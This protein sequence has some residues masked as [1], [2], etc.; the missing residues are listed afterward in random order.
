MFYC[1]LSKNGDVK[2]SIN[3]FFNDFGSIDILINN[4]GILYNGP[5]V[6]FKKGELTKHSISSWDR[7]LALNLNSVFYM[8]RYAT[9]I[10]I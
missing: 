5:L 2:K 9:E 3:D 7:V 10:M 8:T 4:A 1:D 6:G